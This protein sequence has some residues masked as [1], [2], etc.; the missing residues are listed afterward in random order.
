MRTG[1][2]YLE[3]LR[4]GRTVIVDGEVVDDVT[5]HPAFAGIAKTIAG[6]YDFA[7]APAN[8]MTYV[9]PEIGRTALKPFIYADRN[10]GYDD[11]VRRVDEFLV[12]YDLESA[13]NE[14]S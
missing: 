7:A 6:M 3:S 8:D 11:A 1:K 13:A 10:Y 12:S 4:D 2:D 14:E 5:A 9:A